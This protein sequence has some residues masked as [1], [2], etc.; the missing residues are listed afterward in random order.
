[1]KIVCVCLL[2]L[3]SY[4]C[5]LPN[6]KITCEQ[7]NQPINLH[8]I[9]NN[10]NNN[11]SLSSSL[12]LSSIECENCRLLF[13]SL[14]E[15]TNKIK[16]TNNNNNNANQNLGKQ[17]Q[18]TQPV[19]EITTRVPSSSLSVNSN[20]ADQN[21]GSVS[22]KRSSPPQN[23]E[24]KQQPVQK[25]LK[26]SSEHKKD[27][28]ANRVLRAIDLTNIISQLSQSANLLQ[29]YLHQP[30]STFHSLQPPFQGSFALI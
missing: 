27:D 30:F 19:H 2:C 15:I 28:F 8:N 11:N 6:I 23:N 20:N 16:Y 17:E 13:Q 1:M 29:K 25:V 10:H 21:Q 24:D 26:G 14:Q 5:K 7:C 3:T 22:H 4:F 12:L 18:Q 9:N